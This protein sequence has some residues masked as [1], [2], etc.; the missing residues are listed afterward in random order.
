MM[1]EIWKDVPGYEWAYEVSNL[2]R[3]RS[4]DRLVIDSL[5]RHRHLQGKLKKASKGSDGYYSVSLC[6]GNTER[7]VSLHRIVATAFI[8]NPEKKLEVNHIDGDKSNNCLDN[9]EW[10]TPKENIAHA[11]RLGLRK[12]VGY[13]SKRSQKAKE[14]LNW[15]KKHCKP[16]KCLETGEIFKSHSSAARHIGVE[17]TSIDEAI[18]KS[19]PCRGCTFV[20]ITFDEYLQSQIVI[21]DDR[22]SDT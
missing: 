3:I 14:G 5:G 16:V 13:D 7:H 10:V 1:E 18:S 19:R 21:D 15:C 9:L 22:R 12:N 4:K 6:D 11:S 8:P 2:S 20:H 17:S